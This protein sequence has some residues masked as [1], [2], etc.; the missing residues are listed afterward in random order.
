MQRAARD[1]LTQLGGLDDV[2]LSKVVLACPK[3]EISWRV[4]LFFLALPW[5][6]IRQVW[7]WRAD[8]VLFSSLNPALLL[9][10]LA[11]FLRRRE[12]RLMAIAH[13]LDITQGPPI[14]QW[15]IRHSMARLDGIICV[16]RAT[17]QACL[18]RGYAADRLEVLPNGIGQRWHAVSA[19]TPCR[20]RVP[21][22]I[23][24]TYVC[25]AVGRQIPRKGYAWFVD[26]VMP[27]LPE[28]FHLWLVG[29]GPQSKVIERVIVNRSLQH[30]VFPLGL[31]E[32]NQLASVYRL[33]DLFVMPN[34]RINQDMEGFGIVMLEAG[35]HGL[36]CLASCIEGIT[37]VISHENGVLLPA[38]DAE[39]FAL[40]IQAQAALTSQQK[41]HQ[42]ERAAAWVIQHFDW[43]RLLPRYRAAIE[44]VLKQPKAW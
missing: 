9:P 2:A 13:G 1:L 4:P 41:R 29:R 5:R 32:D 25:L 28:H 40:E 30:R 36:Y 23:P 17:A 43:S 22:K 38:R 42:S 27:L 21:T 12:S 3:H 19:V 15:W 31:L 26:A 8:V 11:P 10:V 44:R 39:A 7:L 18:D 16:S 14:A 33:A 6:L 34:L 37:D 24:G 20:K 35:L